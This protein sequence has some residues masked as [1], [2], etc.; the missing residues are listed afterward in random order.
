MYTARRERAQDATTQG[1]QLA[2]ASTLTDMNALLPDLQ[3]AKLKSVHGDV[4][5]RGA[6][7]REVFA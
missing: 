2:E 4:Q 5:R 6:D 1:F 7:F 3:L